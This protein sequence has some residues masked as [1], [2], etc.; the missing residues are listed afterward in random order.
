MKN[1]KTELRALVKAELKALD[2]TEK[3]RRDR[4]LLEALM[5]STSY[6]DCRVLACFLSLPFEVD[7]SLLI[8]QAQKDGKRIL[9]PKTRPEGQMDFVDY[10]PSSL[11]KTPFGTFEPLQGEGIPKE[12][13]DLILVPGL[14]W[15]V[16]GYRLGFGGGFYDRYLLDYPGQT[17]SLCYDF[18][19]QTFEAEAHDIPVGEVLV[20]YETI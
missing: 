6:R 17:L 4:E 14:A 15:N 5:S 20:N 18:Q 10:D 12:E 9:I 8:E 1:K 7:T 19:L 16:D 13:I 11:F 2:R 3:T